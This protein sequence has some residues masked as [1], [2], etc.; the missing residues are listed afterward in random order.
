[1]ASPLPEKILV[2]VD[3]AEMRRRGLRLAMRLAEVNG[4]EIVL[5]TV[6]DDRFPYPDIFSLHMPDADYYRHLRERAAR[7]LEE[8]AAEAPEGV[9][10]RPVVARGKPARVIVEVAREEVPT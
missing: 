9:T 6:I 1:M 7:V 2:P 8:A 4:A 10:V 3:V 5:L